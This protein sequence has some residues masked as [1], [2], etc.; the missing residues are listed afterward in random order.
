ML[1]NIIWNKNLIQRSFIHSSAVNRHHQ[2]EN[3][4]NEPKEPLML[5]KIPGPKSQKLYD[6]INKIQVNLVEFNKNKLFFYN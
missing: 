6:D 2:I 4:Q 5:T 1:K 3:L